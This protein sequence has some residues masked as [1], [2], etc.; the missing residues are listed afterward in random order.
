MAINGD[1]KRK[2]IVEY[3][4]SHLRQN[5]YPPSVR[6]IGAAVGLS[7]TASVARHLRRL[8][9]TGQLSHAP[10]KR[11][12]WRLDGTPRD[13]QSLPLVGHIRAGNPILA[14]EHVEDHVTVSM[15]LFRPSAD[16]LLRVKGDSMIDSGIFPGD[17]VA[18]SLQAEVKDGD[19]VIAMLGDEATVKHLDT[20][21]GRIRLLPANV[22]YEPIE[23]EDIAIVGRVVGLLRTF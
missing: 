3:I 11:R 21:Q 10:F 1:E 16:F 14:Q 18:V 15:D 4:Q 6:E 12:A 17:L 9:E 23:S 8:E 22:N 5:G 2:Q 13:A 7:S 20:R 19:V